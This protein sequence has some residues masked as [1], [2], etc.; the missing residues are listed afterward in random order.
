MLAFFLEGF[1]T[2][3]TI[4][5]DRLAVAFG[6][7]AVVVP[8]SR[9]GVHVIRIRYGIEYA[10]RCCW[11]LITLALVIIAMYVCD[12]ESPDIF[13]RTFRFVSDPA[14]R[15][16]R[17]KGGQ[18]LIIKGLGDENRWVLSVEHAN[19]LNYKPRQC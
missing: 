4:D 17:L 16:V 3:I 1:E 13:R 15:R 10:D 8:G 11:R 18:F 14:L 12:S 19:G 7:F 2:R 5:G 9:R 6:G